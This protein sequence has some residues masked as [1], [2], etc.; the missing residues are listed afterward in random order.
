MYWGPSFLFRP[1]KLARP[2]TK[3]TRLLRLRLK[4]VAAPKLT[5]DAALHVHDFTPSVFHRARKFHVSDFLGGV[6]FMIIEEREFVVGFG[7]DEIILPQ[8]L[9]QRPSRASLDPASN[10]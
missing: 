7:H 6:F 9:L 10:F 3:Q 1:D 2:T 5:T 8:E 4:F